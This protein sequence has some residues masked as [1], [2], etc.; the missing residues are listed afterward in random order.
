M[1]NMGYDDMWSGRSLPTFQ[2]KRQ[3]SPST[4]KPRN[5]K[6]VTCAA[7]SSTVG[8]E[9]VR[10]SET[11]V[12]FFRLSWRHIPKVRTLRHYKHAT[13]QLTTTVKYRVLQAAK[14]LVVSAPFRYCAVPLWLLNM[15]SY[16]QRTYITSV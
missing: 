11:S 13:Q 15:A 7:Y 10:S 8:L 6:E 2:M 14:F 12:K 1:T 16:F 3:P 9:T 5:Q 4:S